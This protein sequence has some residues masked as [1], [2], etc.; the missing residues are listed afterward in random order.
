MRG[1]ASDQIR[2]FENGKGWTTLSSH[3]AIREA[4][5]LMGAGGLNAIGVAASTG[6][7]QDHSRYLRPGAFL[8]GTRKLIGMASRFSG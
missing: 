2:Y 8:E 1:F 7:N 6:C 4:G 3:G 5:S